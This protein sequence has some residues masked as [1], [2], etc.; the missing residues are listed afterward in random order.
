MVER[1]I[2]NTRSIHF[3]YVKTL[4]LKNID[5][6]NYLFKKS[7][8]LTCIFLVRIVSEKNRIA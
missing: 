4:R 7:Y 6:P 3:L 5:R 8:A 1:Q 2:L